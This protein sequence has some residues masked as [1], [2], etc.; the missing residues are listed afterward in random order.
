M[1]RHCCWGCRTQ[2]VVLVWQ[3]VLYACALSDSTQIALQ[4]SNA[5]KVSAKL[6]VKSIH[7]VGLASSHWVSSDLKRI[8]CGF[9]CWNV[10]INN[11]QMDIWKPILSCYPVQNLTLSNIKWCSQAYER[12]QPKRKLWDQ[13]R[14]LTE[15]LTILTLLK[16]RP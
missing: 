8:E 1:E 4:W 9:Q 2:A 12:K 3:P 14:D 6:Q 7:I 10:C 11:L 16:E 13:P 15:T 5:K